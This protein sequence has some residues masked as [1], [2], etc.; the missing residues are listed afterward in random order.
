MLRHRYRVLPRMNF[1]SPFVDLPHRLTVRQNLLIYARLYGLPRSRASGSRSSPRD[2]Q[3]SAVSRTPGGQ[4][5][6]RAEDPRRA[7]QGAAE[8]A[9][10]A[11]ARRADRLARPGYRRLGAQLSRRLACP[12]RRDD[13]DGLAQYERG[14]AAVLGGPDDEGGPYRRSRQPAG[15]D[16][17][18]WPHQSRRGLSAH[19]RASPELEPVHDEPLRTCDPRRR[20][21]L[22]AGPGL[23]DAA[24]LSLSAAQL[25]AAHPRAAVLAD[26]ADADLG[27]HEPVPL[28][29]QQLCLP[30]LR[31]AA[32]RGHAVGCA[33][34]RPA[35]PVD[36]VSR[37]DVGAQSRA[38]LRHPAAAL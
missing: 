28:Q 31:R 32:R 8:R 19:R 16:R 22:F 38:S 12:H 27:V 21:A 20:A 1:S 10:T 17:P 37:G 2:L 3:I 24:A 35:R 30:R 34:P 4:A 11:A 15:A 25:V 36:V 6:G 9:R 13:P 29:Q 7:R 26:L 14:R 33:V 18:L 5:V 23:G